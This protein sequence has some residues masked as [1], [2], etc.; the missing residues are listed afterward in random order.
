M[1]YL[2]HQVRTEDKDAISSYKR[3][4]LSV[5]PQIGTNE[6]KFTVCLFQHNN[7]SWINKGIELHPGKDVIDY[8]HMTLSL[9]SLT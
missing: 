1:T 8:Y 4:I 9:W 3:K 2:K 6:N 5:I 7:I